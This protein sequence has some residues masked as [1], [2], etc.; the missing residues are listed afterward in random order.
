MNQR[1]SNAAMESS[2]QFL[3]TLGAID[4]AEEITSLG[5]VLS[6]LPVDPILGKMLIM[7][8]IFELVDPILTIAAGMSVQSPFMRLPLNAKPEIVKN[9]RLFDSRHGDPFT[10]LNLW[11]SWLAVKSEGK[12]S[13]RSWCKRHGV[14]EQR[15]YE[16]AK[17]KKQ[18][19]DILNE[20]R[21]GVVTGSNQRGGF[22]RK[23]DG[24]K[25]KEQKDI[26]R[27][28]RHLQQSSMKKRKILK[29]EEIEDIGGSND[30]KASSDSVD[31]RDLE[32]LLANDVD[33]LRSRSSRAICSDRDITLI[34][35]IVCSGL[36]PQ[37]AIGDEHN[38]HRNA[39][40]LAFHTKSLFDLSSH[41]VS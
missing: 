40:E 23:D 28:E 34:K 16:I 5:R 25:R 3:Q 7:S 13:S 11:D 22:K 18:F 4:E 38:P 37:L 14:E 32:F 15:V 30:S 39:N 2:I 36:Y 10:L 12:E 26:L 20:F 33:E 6:L 19:E 17:L 9:R 41:N 8:T 29:F 24:R 21:P 31:V 35:M 1:P 27:R